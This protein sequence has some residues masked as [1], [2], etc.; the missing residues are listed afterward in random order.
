[1]TEANTGNGTPQTLE[2]KKQLYAAALSTI[3]RLAPEIV[4]DGNAFDDME[5]APATGNMTDGS[6]SDKVKQAINSLKAATAEVST[7]E[8]ITGIVKFLGEEFGIVI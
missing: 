5:F 1:M 3:K 4:S 2:E 6:Q 8:T 7:V